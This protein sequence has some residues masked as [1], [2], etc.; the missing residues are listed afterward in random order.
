MIIWVAHDGP[1]DLRGARSLKPKL[2]KKP[3]FSEVTDETALFIV[4]FV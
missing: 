2:T 1:I 3:T 4:L